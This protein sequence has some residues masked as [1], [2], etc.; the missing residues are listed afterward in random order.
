MG[1]KQIQLN[2]HFI[3]QI[4]NP[5]TAMKTHLVTHS[6]FQVAQTMS[7]ELPAACHSIFQGVRVYQ[8][9]VHIKLQCMAV[10][11]RHSQP[12]YSGTVSGAFVP[13][14]LHPI[15]DVLCVGQLE[16]YCS[17]SV[18]KGPLVHLF[19]QLP[20]HFLISFNGNPFF[21]NIYLCILRILPLSSFSLVVS[22]YF[23]LS[24]ES[25]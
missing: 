6:G 8:Y 2:K 15:H 18:S 17:S 13:L 19:Y 12:K 23:S 22:S 11:A 1:F 10:S 3:N 4:H 7:E 24:L 20:S 25:Q 21:H 9:R 16:V 14:C 5:Q